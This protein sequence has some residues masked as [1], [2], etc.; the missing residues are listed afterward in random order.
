[1]T[2][3]QI[4]RSAAEWMYRPV[5]HKTQLRGKTKAIPIVGEAVRLLEPLLFCDPEKLYCVTQ[6]GTPW[7]KNSYGQHITR[8]TEKHGLEH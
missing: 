8:A 5:N 3:A 7:N 1:M 6:K 2:P 4:D